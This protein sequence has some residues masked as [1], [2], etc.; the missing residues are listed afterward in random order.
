MSEKTDQYSPPNDDI[1]LLD[2]L[3][4]LWKK[5]LILLLSAVVFSGMG[6]LIAL[7]TSPTYTGEIQVHRLN[8]SEMAGFDAWNEGVRVATQSVPTMT[9]GALIGMNDANVDLSKITSKSLADTFVAS[10]QRG[11]ALV[12]ALR[13]HSAAVQK[14]SG[15]EAEL[16]LMLSA[17]TNDYVLEVDTKS[18]LDTKPDKISII[19][20]T[21]DKVESFKVLSTALEL[22]SNASKDEILSSIQ[23]KLEATRLSRKLELDRVAAEFEG[24][25]RLYEARKQR[26]LT[27]LREQADVARELGIETPAYT[28]SP[29][30]RQVLGEEVAELG[31]DFFES[32]YFLQGYRAIEKQIS[33]IEQREESRDT[34]IVAEIDRLVLSRTLIEK[35]SVLEIMTPLIEKL[36]LNDQ[37]FS[38]VRVDLDKTK[39]ETDDSR[40]LIAIFAA[41]AGVLMTAFLILAQ[42]A[43]TRRSA[44]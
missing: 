17:M 21:S 38:L 34:P 15:D 29:S 26:S 35:H 4:I 12:A 6:V 9:G 23:S 1:D 18:S 36:P 25:L 39:F 41:L 14:F 32:N 37:D 16:D 19:F 8:E 30:P 20:K 11:D 31:L 7:T 33:N 28:Q 10:Y 5:R 3:L 2:L 40:R 43:M 42:H 24:Y 22:I 13:Q 44:G 27:L